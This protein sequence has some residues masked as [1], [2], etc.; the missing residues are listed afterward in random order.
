[1]KKLSNFI[2]FNESVK[3]ITKDNIEDIFIDLLDDGYQFNFYETMQ[4]GVYYFVFRKNFRE[5]FDFDTRTSRYGI[6]DIDAMSKE[7]QKVLSMLKDSKL[8]LE[9]MGYD[10]GFEPDFSFSEDSSISVNCHLCH[11]SIKDED[12]LD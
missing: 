4:S 2:K 12:D 11:Q 9:S 8:R 6:R 3:F 1:M 5:R 7:V 10:I